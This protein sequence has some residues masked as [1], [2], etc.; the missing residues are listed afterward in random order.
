MASR[1]LR[2]CAAASAPVLI[3]LRGMSATAALR[4]RRFARDHAAIRDRT[5]ALA[6]AFRLE[7]KCRPPYWELVR[8]ARSAK[9]AA[10]D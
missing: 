5:L 7:R 3:V 4:N 2:R 1:I 9:L 6:E 10:A 8:L